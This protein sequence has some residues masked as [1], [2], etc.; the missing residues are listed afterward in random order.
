MVLMMMMRIMP[1]ILMMRLMRKS[2][3]WF[4]YDSPRTLHQ[5]DTMAQV[6]P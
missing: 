5:P 6:A 3:A 2:D 4:E 1:M